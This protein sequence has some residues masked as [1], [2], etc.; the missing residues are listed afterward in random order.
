MQL[1][2]SDWS[3]NLTEVNPTISVW[4]GKLDKQVPISH[5]EIYAKHLQNSKIHLIDDESHLSILYN[6]MG[7]IIDS[8]R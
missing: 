2:T 5:S 8:I 4:Q 7:E 6:R 3:I 1:L